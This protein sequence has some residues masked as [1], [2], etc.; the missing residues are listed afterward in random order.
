MKSALRKIG[1]NSTGTGFNRG[2]QNLLRGSAPASLSA[3]G[4]D[5]ISEA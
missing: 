1:K 4:K 3:R 5:R 2:A